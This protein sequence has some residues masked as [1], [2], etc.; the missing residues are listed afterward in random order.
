MSAGR[1]LMP[2]I[3]AHPRGAAAPRGWA[4][5]GGRGAAFGRATRGLLLGQMG[6]NQGV[7]A[8]GK[9]VISPQWGRV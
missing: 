3:G 9:V 5:M 2:P 8:P 7:N 1:F 6:K 4:P